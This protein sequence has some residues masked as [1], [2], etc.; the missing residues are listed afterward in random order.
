MPRS[1]LRWMVHNSAQ[2]AAQRIVGEAAQAMALE[3][4]ST[5]DSA[6]SRGDRNPPRKPNRCRLE[7]NLGLARWEALFRTVRPL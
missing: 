4:Q 7:Q 1:D 6:R 2:Q 3:D 5:D